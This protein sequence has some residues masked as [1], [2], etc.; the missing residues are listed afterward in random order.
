MN[1]LITINKNYLKYAFV[2][3]K[4]CISNNQKEKIKV[5]IVSNDISVKDMEYFFES[6]KV[7]YSIIGF[8][9]KLFNNAPTSK[10]YPNEIYYRLL[11]S[12]YLPDEVDRILYLDP[13][14]IILK[15]LNDLY[16][17]NFDGNY[18]IGASNVKKFLRKFNEL[19]NN[20]SKNAPYINTGVL[21][22]NLSGL[23][24][25][26][27]RGKIINYLDKNK[28]RLFLPDQDILQGVFGNKIKVINNHVYNLSDREIKKH[29]LTHRNKIDNKWVEENTS[30]I[31]YIGKNKPWKKKYKG[32]LKK[33]YTKYEENK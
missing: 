6:Q 26:N 12:M 27:V 33:Y 1:I 31:H 9:D 32:I 7:E 23:R 11:A 8:D 22:I 19:K 14:V 29:N 17:M 4:S 16:N 25:V 2:M 20:A 13:D 24:K 21:L 28:N 18:Y 30:I 3:L 5:F 15:S 10:R